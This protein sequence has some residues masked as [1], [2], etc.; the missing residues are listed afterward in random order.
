MILK[1]KWKKTPGPAGRKSA[2]TLLEVL[3]AS[4]I[5]GI[6]FVAILASVGSSTRISQAS[7]EMT[8]AIFLTQEIRE[9][10]ANLPF[11]D[12]DP[13]D[14]AKPV[15]PDAYSSPGVPYVDDLD[16]LMNATFSP[17]RNGLGDAITGMLGWSQT[18][19]LTWRSPSAINTSVVAGTSDI[20]HVQVTVSKNDE[21]LLQTGWLVTEEGGVE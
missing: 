8:Q 20:I 21:V 16:D 13:A 11:R 17:P 15:G 6:G 18:V 2:F 9:W 12:T 19:N 10:T 5:L 7:S 1:S 4:V 14:I 3:C